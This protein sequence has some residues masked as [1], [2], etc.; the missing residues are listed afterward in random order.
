MRKLL[1]LFVAVLG[2]VACEK[3]DHNVEY[4]VNQI[5]AHELNGGEFSEG[6]SIGFEGAFD[7]AKGGNFFSGNSSAKNSDEITQGDHLF[8]GIV[9]VTAVGA[10]TRSTSLTFVDMTIEDVRTEVDALRIPNL[11]G[12]DYDVT[13]TIQ[14][15]GVNGTRNYANDSGLL[16]SSSLKFKGTDELEVT[17]SLTLDSTGAVIVLGMQPAD[18]FLRVGFVPHPDNGDYVGAIDFNI[19]DESTTPTATVEMGY[20]VS[21]NSYSINITVSPDL[22]AIVAGGFAADLTE[23]AELYKDK[24]A[25]IALTDI[26][27][28]YSLDRVFNVI[29]STNGAI[30][31]DVDIDDFEADD[32][33][34]DDTIT[35]KFKG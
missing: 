4:D 20:R 34:H 10:V 2:T 28:G 11:P 1:L 18:A 29:Y 17:E 27:D 22:D 31:I 25:T 12:G 16:G 32:T 8:S 9:E 7:N 30:E 6:Y 23:A 26:T 5:S 33:S 13:T 15:T 19:V 3:D 14:Q 35:F 24:Q 21:P